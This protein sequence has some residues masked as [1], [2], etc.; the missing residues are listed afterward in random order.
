MDN[1]KA[2]RLSAKV[3]DDL[4]DTATDNEY[5]DAMRTAMPEMY[6]FADEFDKMTPEQQ[7]EI[8]ASP[9]YGGNG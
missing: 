3:Y 1:N 5:E 9:L 6:G 2:L 7:A 4:P 8:L